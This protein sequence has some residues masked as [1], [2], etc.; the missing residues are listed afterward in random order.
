LDCVYS[1]ERFFF[2][3]QGA[4]EVPDVGQQ[5]QPDGAPGKKFR[6]P[7]PYEEALKEALGTRGLE[8]FRVKVL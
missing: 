3:S 2:E 4:W 1:L 6:A 7:M 5:H 8:A